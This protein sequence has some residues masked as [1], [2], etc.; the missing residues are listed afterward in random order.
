MGALRLLL[1]ATWAAW[2][3]LELV[4]VLGPTVVDGLRGAGRG[5]DAVSAGVLVVCAAVAFGTAFPLSRIPFG[6]MPAPRAATLAA[7]LAVMW[8]GLALCAWAVHDLGGPFRAVVLV[9]RDRRPVTS[10][11]YRH[12]RHPLHSGA[13]LAAAG[14]GLALGHWTSLLVLVLGWAVGLGCRLR[15]DEETLRQAL[16]AEYEGYRARTRML[17]PLLY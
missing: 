12:V 1:T 3:W 9:R 10:G 2:I 13:L 14:L 7:G 16:G 4:V 5:R 11:P 6:A 15:A 8:L 17:I